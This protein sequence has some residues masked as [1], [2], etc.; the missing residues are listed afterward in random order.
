[1]AGGAGVEY[2]FGYELPQNDLVAED[3]RSRDKTWDFARFSLDFMQKQRIPYHQMKNANA[4]AGNA[5]DD[6][7]VYCFAKPGEI[8]LVYLP[9]GGSAQLD[10][11]VVSG[12]LKV[13]W[14]DPRNGGPMRSGA[15]KS[16]KG[17]GSAALGQPPSDP[18]EDWLAVVTR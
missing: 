11:S 13:Q 6:N 10:L 16:V 9:K 15:V 2:Y 3:L 12:S 5:K 4:L 1:M 14:F 7:S 8:Y 17:G 18:E